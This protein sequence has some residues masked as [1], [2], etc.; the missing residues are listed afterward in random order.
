MIEER[1]MK[2]LV[3]DE[4]G[5]SYRTTNEFFCSWTKFEQEIFA[6]FKIDVVVN[7]VA[8]KEH[9]KIE[10]SQTGSHLNSSFLLLEQDLTS[11]HYGN[12]P[13]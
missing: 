5:M 2:I 11:F 3:A 1:F 13:Y 9:Y 10:P 8:T 6:F 4:Y 12:M 7:Q